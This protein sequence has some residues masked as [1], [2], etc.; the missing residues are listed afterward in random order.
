[1]KIFLNLTFIA[2]SSVM[3]NGISFAQPVIPNDVPTEFSNQGGIINTRH[4]MMQSTMAS[5]GGTIMNA[6]RNNYNEVCVYCHTPHGAATNATVPLWNRTLPTGTTYQ[7]YNQLNTSSLT[8]LVSQPGGASLPCLSCHDGSQATDAIL[9]MPGSGQYSTSPA[10]WNYVAGPGT[11][12]SSQHLGLASGFNNVGTPSSTSCMSCHNP[13]FGSGNAGDPTDFTAFLIGTDLRNDHPVGINFPT[14][15]GP[16][17]DWKTPTGAV[18]RGGS[19]TSFFDEDSNGRMDKGDIRMYGNGPTDSRV[20]CASCHDPHGVPS[21]GTGSV[22]NATFLRKTNAGS[23]V[24]LT[25][26]TK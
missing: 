21:A 20:E 22:F 14:T 6:S 18:T 26:H 10:P 9:N 24:C 11:T 19:T 16:G 15:S 7:T 2:W 17:T 3:L 1:M 23:V 4:N 25:C 8:G 13:S 5:G 12:R